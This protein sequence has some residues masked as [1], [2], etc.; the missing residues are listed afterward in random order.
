MAEKRWNPRFVAYARATGEPDPDRALA[1]DGDAYPGGKMTGFI[2]WIR[3]R[4]TAW[5][6]ANG[7]VPDRPSCPAPMLS[8][9]DHESFDRFIG[10]A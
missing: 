4:W 10:A 3:E 5:Y 1:R 8:Q 7:R 9:A 2:L 6:L